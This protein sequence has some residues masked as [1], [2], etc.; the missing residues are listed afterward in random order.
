MAGSLQLCMN[1]AGISPVQGCEGA[2]QSI[3]IAWHKDEMGMVGHEAPT[4]D[5]NIRRLAMGR[6]QITIKRI[7]RQIEERLL[8]RWVTWWGNPGMTTRAKRAIL[9]VLRFAG[10]AVN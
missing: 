4:P 6:Q 3:P 8:P 10:Q 9:A 5:S 1:D 2:A 7:I